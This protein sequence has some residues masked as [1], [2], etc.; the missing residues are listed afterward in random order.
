MSQLLELNHRLNLT[1]NG[2]GVFLRSD[3]LLIIA[4]LHIGFE[5]SMMGE[6][7]YLPVLQYPTIESS[8][9]EMLDK[10]SVNHLVINGDFK[11]EFGS[12]TEREW[13]EILDLLDVL[14][15]KKVELDLVRGNHDNFLINVLKSRNKIIFDPFL[16]VDDILISHGHKQFQIPEK[17][18]TMILAHEH[19]AVVFKDEAGGRH[20]FKC[21]LF[22]KLEDIDVLVLPAYSPMA[23]GSA[24]NIEK[25]HRFDSGIF[26]LM[27]INEFIPV[28][29]DKGEILKFPPLKDLNKETDY[30]AW[31]DPLEQS[32][33]RWEEDDFE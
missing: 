16:V 3:G 27:D 11:H 33:G 13:T 6:G 18:T 12:A 19:P 21:Y 28:I 29:V 7:T 32:D 24:V 20:K 9:L 30:K 17:I 4:D 25:N 10:H 31:F 1:E 15:K 14:N 8:I 23:P 5:L 2:R 22:G 26:K